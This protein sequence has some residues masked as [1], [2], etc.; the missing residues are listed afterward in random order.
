MPATRIFDSSGRVARPPLARLPGEVVSWLNRPPPP[1]ASSVPRGDGHAVLVVPAFLCGDALTA[2]LR[3]FLAD[4]GYRPHGWGLGV[5]LGPTPRL[6]A[7]LRARAHAL[8]AEGPITVIGI[9]LGGVLARDLAYDRPRALRRVVTIGS[10]FHLPTASPIAPLYRLCMPLHSRD[11]DLDRLATPLPVPATA[12]YSEEDGI[13][14]PESC[15]RESEGPAIEV[16]GTH[17]AISANP[18]TL[19]AVAEALAQPWAPAA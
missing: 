13:V 14:A 11:I 9:S 3:R 12:L 6:L 18:R 5:N 15:R 8:A 1:P 2:P 19:R 17:I 7:G 10:P 16:G 4:C